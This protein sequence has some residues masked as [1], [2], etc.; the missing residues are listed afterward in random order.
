MKN[1]A[2]AEFDL[3][4]LETLIDDVRAEKRYIGLDWRM[5][6]R[7]FLSV[8]YR[9]LKHEILGFAMEEF[10]RKTGIKLPY[11]LH[12]VNHWM[13]IEKIS[14]DRHLHP[15]EAV[16][17]VARAVTQLA[18]W[19]KASTDLP[20]TRR[21][22]KFTQSGNGMGSPYTTVNLWEL[23][24]K[25]PSPGGFERRVWKVRRRAQQILSGWHGDLQ[26]SWTAI[27]RALVVTRN[28]GKAALIA[29]AG[30]LKNNSEWRLSYS[31]ARYF[32]TEMRSARFPVA[33]NSDGV[34]ARREVEP[35]LRKLGCAVY[36]T[37]R[38]DEFGRLS[39]AWLVKRGDRSF[40][41]DGWSAHHAL[42]EALAA[43]K[44]R[45]RLEREEADLVGFLQG[46]EGYMPLVYLEHSY[47]A[48]NCVPGTAE[49]IRKKGWSGRKLIPAMWLLPHLDYGLVQNVAMVV[50]N[51]HH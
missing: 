26:P 10:E 19:L 40:H 25:N 20:G 3:T 29:A 8:D 51:D 14:K 37:R 49:W 5:K 27:A 13:K 15:R 44:E 22:I 18:G 33:D 36:L 42:K 1:L 48:G 4:R 45:A 35:K 7:E 9:H 32:L 39:L 16:R 23:V 11:N 47:R 17:E 43:W 50:Y 2:H 21:V 46:D 38:Q 6:N 30:T 28:V 31:E 34:K 24:S 41:T 12:Q